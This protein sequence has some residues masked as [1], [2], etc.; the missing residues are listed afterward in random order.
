MDKRYVDIVFEIIRFLR[1][2]F[3]NVN[4]IC[5]FLNI[6]FGL[7]KRRWINRVF[8]FIVIY[9]GFNSC[10]VDFFDDVLMKFIYVFEILF[11]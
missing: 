9:F 2:E 1:N 8:L 11:G 6:F 4:I 5:G 3:E 7:L 10:I